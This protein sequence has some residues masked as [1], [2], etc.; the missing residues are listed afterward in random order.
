MDITKWPC[1]KC[2]YSK[3]SKNELFCKFLNRKLEKNNYCPEY[4][5]NW[6]DYR[7]ILEKLKE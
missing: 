1:Y 5:P 6:D 2:N 3:Y 7:N 4:T